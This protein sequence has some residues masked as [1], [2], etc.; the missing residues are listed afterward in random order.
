VV[1]VTATSPTVD[2]V[3]RLS[4]VGLDGRAML[5]SLGAVRATAPGPTKVAI[6]LD[7]VAASWVPGEC[8]RVD[9]GNSAFPLF[10]RNSGTETDALDVGSPGEFRRALVIVNHDAQRPS[11]VFLPLLGDG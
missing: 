6:P 10:P 2:L 3:V 1:N 8:I 11:S 9:I 4:K 7:P 5:L